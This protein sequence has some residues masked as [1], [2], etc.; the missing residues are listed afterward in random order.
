MP[1]CHQMGTV[2]LCPSSHPE[3]TR[4]NQFC[5]PLT[6]RLAEAECG[7]RATLL[8]L[9][10]LWTLSHLQQILSVH[11]GPTFHDCCCHGGSLPITQN[12][13]LCNSLLTNSRGFQWAWRPVEDAGECKIAPPNQRTLGGPSSSEM[14]GFCNVV[15]KT[16]DFESPRKSKNLCEETG[17]S[18]P[19]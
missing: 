5:D 2:R 7:I 1:A 14:C 19:N 4:E 11:N 12:R 6:F 15:P 17:S 10:D 3:P 16:A 9:Q 13:Q 18:L 8:V